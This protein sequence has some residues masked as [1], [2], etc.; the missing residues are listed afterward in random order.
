MR[1]I[2]FQELFNDPAPLDILVDNR[3][4]L[5]GTFVTPLGKLY[6][7][8]AHSY[9]D[10]GFLAREEAVDVWEVVFFLV[11]DGQNKYDITDTGEA[12]TVFST[13]AEFLEELIERKNPGVIY[14]SGEEPSRVRLYDT[15]AK[16]IVQR[17]PAYTNADPPDMH[18]GKG[19]YVFTRKD[20]L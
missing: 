17:F 8:V 12:F 18:V 13:V 20:L 9:M 4:E 2:R 7:I 5:V 1:R 6:K 3:V 11:K 10:I 19:E 15:F 16:K 14:F